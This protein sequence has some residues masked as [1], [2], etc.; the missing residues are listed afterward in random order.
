IRFGNLQSSNR[1]VALRGRDRCAGLSQRVDLL[2]RIRKGVLQ[3]IESRAQG[4]CDRRIA[5]IDQLS[6][7]AACQIAFRG[8][9]GLVASTE[10]Q[11][12][13]GQPGKRRLDGQRL[14]L[15]RHGELPRSFVGPRRLLVRPSRLVDASLNEGQ[16]AEPGDAI[17]VV[18]AQL[19]PTL[20]KRAL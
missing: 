16:I 13:Q 19:P 20:T 3:R 8:R 10:P 7:E 11:E 9:P 5:G 4:S 18:G 12:G 6:G 1:T 15:T 17:Y 2:M 14:A